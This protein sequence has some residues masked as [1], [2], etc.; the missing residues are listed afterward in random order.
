[1]VFQ[2]GRVNVR[3]RIDE[4]LVNVGFGQGIEDFGYKVFPFGID[5]GAL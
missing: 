2:V 1:M 5:L 3:Q 4:F